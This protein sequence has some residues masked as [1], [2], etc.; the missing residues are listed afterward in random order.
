MQPR[1]M[2]GV[3]TNQTHPHDHPQQRHQT[4]TPQ[5]Q[6]IK[7]ISAISGSDLTLVLH[8]YYINN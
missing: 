1:P 2:G 8:M 4:A 5:S 6:P 3:S 7:N